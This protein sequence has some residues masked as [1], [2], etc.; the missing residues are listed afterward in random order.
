MKDSNIFNLLAAILTSAAA[1][2]T[3]PKD[4]LNLKENQTSMLVENIRRQLMKDNYD[5]MLEEATTT[6]ISSRTNPYHIGDVYGDETAPKQTTVDSAEIGTENLNNDDTINYTTFKPVPVRRKSHS[7]DRSKY[8]TKT[9]E[10]NKNGETNAAKA[11]YDSDAFRNESDE[12]PIAASTTGKVKYSIL[13]VKRPSRRSGARAPLL[14]EEKE[15]EVSLV[16]LGEGAVPQ[17]R[18]PL[19]RRQYMQAERGDLSD[20]SA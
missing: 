16:N 7:H 14:R 5:Y 4:E 9:E 20:S 8:L 3:S 6:I 10:T 11:M 2:N 15:G 1:P 18:L 12:R 17:L 19:S 13:K